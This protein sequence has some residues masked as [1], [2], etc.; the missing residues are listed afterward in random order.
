MSLMRVILFTETFIPKVD[1]IVTVIRLLLDHLTERGVETMIVAPDLGDV[2]P[3]YNRTRII[4]PYSIRLKFYDELATG[5][6]TP[7]IWWHMRRFKPDVAHLFHPAVIGTTG[8]LLAKAFRIPIVTSFHV[9]L[10]AMARY[11]GIPYLAP[12]ADFGM[13]LAFK[14]ADYTLA[15]SRPVQ[16]RLLKMGVRK[17]GLWGRGVDADKFHPRH[18]DADMRHALSDGHSDAPLLL[19]VGRL[20][21]EKRLQDLRPVLDQVPGARL[22]IVGDGPERAAL[23]A[24]FAGTPA[25]FMGYLTGSDLSRAY[26]SSDLFVFPSE[27]EAFGLVVVEAMAAGL[28]V[29]AARVGGVMDTVQERVTGCTFDPGDVAALIDGVR[30][31]AADAD[32]RRVM[33][34]TA[35]AYAETRSWPSMMEDV[36]QLYGRLL[37]DRGR[38]HHNGESATFRVH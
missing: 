31:V 19:Y 7:N 24:V 30:F 34:Q 21:K 8:L 1:G 37:A 6:P 16:E 22:A 29:V 33:G 13:W 3:Y 17:V 14:G 28:P 26:A 4:T 20:S 15:P 10:A 18:Y 9:D 32:R 12:V 23:E 5:T 2:P 27:M 38:G 35:R 25:R 36:Y 11:V